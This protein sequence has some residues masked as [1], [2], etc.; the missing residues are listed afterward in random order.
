MW[1]R[2]AIAKLIPES[3]LEQLKFISRYDTLQSNYLPF[4][5][6]HFSAALDEKRKTL[7]KQIFVAAAA[8]RKE[9]EISFSTRRKPPEKKIRSF[10]WSW[11]QW[12]R[13]SFI[14]LAGALFV[15]ATKKWNRPTNVVFGVSRVDRSEDK[16]EAE[17]NCEIITG[18]LRK[19]FCPRS[20][21]LTRFSSGP[22]EA[23]SGGI[24]SIYG[25]FNQTL[26]NKIFDCFRL[27]AW[28][29]IRSSR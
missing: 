1:E 23:R 29:A 13:V 2:T 3:K 14:F 24:W 16:A 6:G 27:A 15:A 22:C 11:S 26:R 21:F 17:H 8:R 25:L 4:R 5:P 7:R 19:G 18:L 28:K 20:F 10:G 12:H 9:R